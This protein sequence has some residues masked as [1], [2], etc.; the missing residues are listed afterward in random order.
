MLP[1]SCRRGPHRGWSLPGSPSPLG[2]EGAQQVVKEGGSLLPANMGLPHT[3]T[4]DPAGTAWHCNP[5]HS[6]SR[7]NAASRRW[8]AGHPLMLIQ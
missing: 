6:S 2:K 5:A 1:A 8:Q 3:Y 4:Y 7:S